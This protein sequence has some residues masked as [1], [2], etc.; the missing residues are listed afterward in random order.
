MHQIFCHY[1]VLAKEWA[2]RLPTMFLM[3]SALAITAPSQAANDQVQR[4]P[5][6]DWVSPSEP[7]PVPGDASGLVFVRYQDFLVHL[8]NDGEARYS[9]YRMRILHPN[10]LQLGN[11]SIVWN[12]AAGGPTVHFI[13]VHRDGA[14]IDVLADSSFEILRREDQ[15]ETAMLDGLLTAVLRVPDLRVGDEIEFG[16]TIRSNEPTLGNTVSG[17]L[18]LGTEPPPGRFRLGVSW[19]GGQEPTLRLTPDIAASAER[20]PRGVMLRFDNPALLAPPNEAPPR[21]AWQR[22]IEYSDFPSWPAISSRFSPLYRRASTLAADSPLRAEA[23]RIAAAHADPMA[24]AR[25]ALALVQRE[26]RY[27]YVGLNA[28]NL[29]PVSAD[30]TWRRRYGDCKGKTV[31]LLA[32]LAEL[33]ISAEAVLVNN[34]ATDDGLNERLPNASMFDHVLVRAQIGGATYWLD[35]TLPHVAGPSLSPVLPYRWVLPLSDAGSPLQS[36]PWRPIERPEEV[37][38]YEIDVRA[39]FDAPARITTTTI[40]RGMP[41]LAQY[42]QLSALTPAQ[43]LSGVRQQLTGSSWQEVQEVRWRY[44]ERAGASILTISG[45]GP[46][47][48]E[49]SGL[50]VRSLSLPGGGFSAP[51]RRIRPTDQNQTLPYYTAPTYNCHVTT[52]RIPSSTQAAQWTNNGGFDT[53]L[54]G[55]HYFRAFDFRD[56]AIRMVRGSRT[57]RN[58]IS[59]ADARADNARVASFD[60]STAQVSFRPARISPRTADSRRIPAT[61]EIDWTADDIPCLT[62]AAPASAPLVAPATP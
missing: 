21:Y 28:G 61:Y 30:E 56:G 26:V 55:H 38:L 15:L 35:G 8:D 33:G 31:L 13:R 2:V 53:R 49:T 19:A 23:R 45:L 41:G 3:A 60:N 20:R 18:F 40:L 9:G 43:L 6:P 4:G 12:P 24:R 32:L 11:I 1:R 37:G 34:G 58:E 25:A 47:D 50:G 16:L 54:F 5:V 36:L 14:V 22:I 10:A 42:V 52:V 57:E 27:V 51:N 44:D 62:T 7:L 29:T 17:M 46:V 59:A 48:W 39:G